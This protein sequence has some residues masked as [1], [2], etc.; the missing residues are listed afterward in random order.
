MNPF[1]KKTLNLSGSIFAVFGVF[2]VGLRLR[3]YGTQLDFHTLSSMTWYVIIGL[4]MVYGAANLLLG[5]AWKYLLMS[6]GVS[7]TW[8]WTLK[9]YG[10]TQLAKYMPGNIFQFAG[11]QSIGLA[12]GLPGWPLAKSIIWEI[13][14]LSLAGGLFGL[15]VLPLLYPDFSNHFSSLSFGIIICCISVL[16]KWYFRTIL[17]V[18]AF[19]CDLFFLSVSGMIFV[20]M[21]QLT[22]V[23]GWQALWLHLCGAY[24]IAWLVG[25]LTPGAPSGVGV[26]EMVLLFLL[27]GV[28]READLLMAVILSRVVT[29]LG[30]LVLFVAVLPVNSDV[31]PFQ[32]VPVD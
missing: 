15:L 23:D 30:D 31:M 9:T 3:H 17:I 13:G 29:V 11:R 21:I 7:T 19:I 10:V 2:Y 16:L 25:L 24:V 14:L 6:L 12:A 26:R 20:C 28:M 1:L 8:R 32:R 22:S 18:R 27:S 4:S 5:S